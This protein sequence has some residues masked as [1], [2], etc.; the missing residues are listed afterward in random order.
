MSELLLQLVKSLVA[1]MAALLTPEQ[2]K[3][4]IDRAFDAVEDKVTNSSTRWDDTIVL[5]IVRALRVALSVPDDDDQAA[6]DKK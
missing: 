6:L 1:A 3:S 5:P 4:I 2:V